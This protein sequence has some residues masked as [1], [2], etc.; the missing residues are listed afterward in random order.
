MQLTMQ[1]SVLG[2]S[3]WRIQADKRHS[4]ADMTSWAQVQLA[5]VQMQ[6]KEERVKGNSSDRHDDGGAAHD[7]HNVH[8]NRKVHVDAPCKDEVV[9]AKNAK[10]GPKGRNWDESE[11]K[12]RRIKAREQRGHR[13]RTILHLT[14]VG[15]YKSITAMHNAAT[16]A[17]RSATKLQK[18]GHRAKTFVKRKHKKKHKHKRG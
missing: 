5:L 10:D 9:N 12:S 2:E 7:H 16:K 4:N 17:K 11:A 14:E 6:D 13:A 3:Y 1:Q 15:K 18:L 8:G